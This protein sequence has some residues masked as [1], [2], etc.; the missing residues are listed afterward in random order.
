M[1]FQDSFE[2]FKESKWVFPVYTLIIIFV[3]I[4][5]AYLNT[6]LATILIPVTMFAIPYYMGERRIRFF[7]LLGVIVIIAN[8]SILGL[9]NADFISNYQT[10]EQKS[11]DKLTI[12]R[13]TISPTVGDANTLFEFSVTITANNTVPASVSVWANVSDVQEYNPLGTEPYVLAMVESDIG[14]TNL[15]DGKDYQV[16]YQFPK[17][18]YFY[19]FSAN[20]NGTWYTTLFYDDLSGTHYKALG[21]INA[22]FPVIFLIYFQAAF[23]FMLFTSILFAIFV[24]MYWWL[25]RSRIERAK[26]E[27]RMREA[28]ELESS[29]EK[30]PEF[31]CTNC[32][33]PVH[34]DAM[35]C[36]HCGAVF[37]ADEEDIEEETDEEE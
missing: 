31:E 13:G 24:M 3:A 10:P 28:G 20:V 4:G 37:E 22:D 30:V 18:V 29:D 8:S 32:G 12:T 19:H 6:C 1:A 26:W 15:A 21:P 11:A 33:R 7:A 5:L 14:D 9:L 23:L 35:R 2:K 34:E 27:D 36:P 17:A 16:S 25:G